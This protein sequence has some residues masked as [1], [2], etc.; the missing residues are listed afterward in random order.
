MGKTHF[1]GIEIGDPG[2]GE[3]GLWSSVTQTW[4]FRFT[5][6]AA[7]QKAPLP[8]KSLI[9][10]I[11]VL[12]MTGALV[13]GTVR[14]ATTNDVEIFNGAATAGAALKAEKMAPAG[15]MYVSLVAGAATPGTPLNVFVSII[16]G[17]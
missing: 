1:T 15:V 3:A 8:D 10:E 7:G 12:D 9:T 14:V 16:P 6:L 4:K 17:Q 5:A 2:H 13:A 11:R